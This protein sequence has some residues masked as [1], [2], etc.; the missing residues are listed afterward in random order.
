M[1]RLAKTRTAALLFL[2]CLLVGFAPDIYSQTKIKNEDKMDN[3]MKEQFEKMDWNKE[4]LSQGLVFL[5]DK[6]VAE[7]KADTFSIEYHVYN[8]FGKERLVRVGT[9]YDLDPGFS[10]GYKG[11]EKR[12]HHREITL[13]GFIEF[14]RQGANSR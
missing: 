3:I 9:G 12:Q 7:C 4:Y 13:E 14:L 6:Y 1:L 2:I 11:I 10:P 5:W 8:N